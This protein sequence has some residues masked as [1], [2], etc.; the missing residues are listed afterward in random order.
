MPI[1]AENKHRYPTTWGEIRARILAR[2]KNR[3]ENQDCGAENYMPH[4]ITG[5]RVVLTIAHLDHTPEHCEDDN[6]RAWCQRYHNRY[7]AP[8]RAQGIK[9]RRH[10]SAGHI[11]LFQ[12]NGVHA[13]PKCH[14]PMII[15]DV[16]GRLIRS[17][18][19]RE[20]LIYIEKIGRV[21]H[22]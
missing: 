10:L 22:V 5:S 9:A 2:A 11:S 6:L 13:C 7:D 14:E 8:V 18:F 20:A 19:C 21:K 16:S 1:R 17:C 12:E 15:S 4:P 3:C